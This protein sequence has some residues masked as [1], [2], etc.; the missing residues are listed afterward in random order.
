MP[1][2]A[3]SFSGIFFI[4][5]HKHYLRWVLDITI[6]I[7]FC[8]ALHWSITMPLDG[9]P[10][11]HLA[12]HSKSQ[13]KDSISSNKSRPHPSK[14]VCSWWFTPTNVAIG[15]LYLFVRYVVSKVTTSPKA[16]YIALLLASTYNT[17]LT[18]NLSLWSMSYTKLQFF[19]FILWN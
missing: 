13:T 5:C 19:S 8:I 11:M 12:Q 6:L 18:W 3:L 1:L 9:F 4:I 7:A 17:F 10:N 16:S 15:I 2:Y 14:H